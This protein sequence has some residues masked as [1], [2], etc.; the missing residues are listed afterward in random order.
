MIHILDITDIGSV[1][2]MIYELISTLLS[3]I[4]NVWVFFRVFIGDI[5][6][7]IIKIFNQLPSLFQYM[8]GLF[9]G[10]LVVFMIGRFISLI[11]AV[12]K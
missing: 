11:I 6:V 1:L 2:E 5:P 4:Y 9:I 12:K 10:F 3:S 7:L 8:L